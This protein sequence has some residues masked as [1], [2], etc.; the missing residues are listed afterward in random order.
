MMKPHGSRGPAAAIIRRRQH[1]TAPQPTHPCPTWRHTSTK[2]S[3][4]AGTHSSCSCAQT[5]SITAP[6]PCLHALGRCRARGE[7]HTLPPHTSFSCSLLPN[8]G[9]SR[10]SSARS[11]HPVAAPYGGGGGVGAAHLKHPTPHARNAMHAAYQ[12]T[13]ASTNT[14]WANPA[15]LADRRCQ[16]GCMQQRATAAQWRLKHN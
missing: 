2:P 7:E 14:P 1:H 8:A 16:T 12:S 10:D 11:V 4:T 9:N 13:T 3:N 6:Q 15:T 5:T